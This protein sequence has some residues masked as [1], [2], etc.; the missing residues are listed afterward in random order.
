MDV[1]SCSLSSHSSRITAAFTVGL[2]FGLPG[3]LPGRVGTSP[4][5]FTSHFPGVNPPAT[6]PF[7][8]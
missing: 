2:Y 1:A 4:V 3:V 8:E 5:R 7:D 6:L